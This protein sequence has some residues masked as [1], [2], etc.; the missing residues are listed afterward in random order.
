MLFKV[1]SNFPKNQP[2][3][4]ELLIIRGGVSDT[5]FLCKFRTLPTSKFQLIVV[6]PVGLIVI[7]LLPDFIIKSFEPPQL[8][9]SSHATEL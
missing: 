9:P 2:V 4:P 6:S 5:V 3:L 8:T 7:P 1:D